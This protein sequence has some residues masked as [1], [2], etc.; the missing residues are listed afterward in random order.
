LVLVPGSKKKNYQDNIK[1][2]YIGFGMHYFLKSLS[3]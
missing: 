3:F 2:S 1:H